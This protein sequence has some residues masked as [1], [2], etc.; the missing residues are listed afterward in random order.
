MG[1]F[2]NAKPQFLL[3]QPNTKKNI[4]YDYIYIKYPKEANA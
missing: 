1:K 2:N 4:L 3:H